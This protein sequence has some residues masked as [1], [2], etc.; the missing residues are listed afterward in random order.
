MTTMMIYMTI[1]FQILTEQWGFVWGASSDCSEII[2][3]NSYVQTIV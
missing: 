1:Y 3:Q 2:D